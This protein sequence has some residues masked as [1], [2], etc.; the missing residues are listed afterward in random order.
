MQIN[1]AKEYYAALSRM[2][3]M[4]AAGELKWSNPEFVDLNRACLR[5]ERK[6]ANGEEAL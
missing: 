2:H 1:N 6:L 4:H 3:T 5:F